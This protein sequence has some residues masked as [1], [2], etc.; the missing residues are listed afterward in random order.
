V[1]S[2]SGES[3]PNVLIKSALNTPLGG[4]EFTESTLARKGLSVLGRRKRESEGCDVVGASRTEGNN[5]DAKT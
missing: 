4:L 1:R 5:T 3:T 2:R